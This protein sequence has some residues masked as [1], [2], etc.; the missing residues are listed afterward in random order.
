MLISQ[1]AMLNIYVKGYFLPK[2]LP[3]H[4]HT[5]TH[6][7]THTANRLHYMTAENVIPMSHSCLRFYSAILS[8]NF[9]V[10]QNHRV[11]LHMLQMQQIT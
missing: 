9:I 3:E 10:Q 1:T 6:T 11:Q 7:G 2:L 8:R 4:T 5:H